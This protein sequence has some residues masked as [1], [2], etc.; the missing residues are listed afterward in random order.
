LSLASIL[1][2]DPDRPVLLFSSHGAMDDIFTVV[3]LELILCWISS[4]C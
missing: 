2:A 3:G 4:A 1:K